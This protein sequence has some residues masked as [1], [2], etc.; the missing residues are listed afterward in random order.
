ML[1][2]V[3]KLHFS[4]SF[5]I[6]LAPSLPFVP[7]LEGSTLRR[8]IGRLRPLGKFSGSQNKSI[9]RKNRFIAARNLIWLK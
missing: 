5:R 9:R 1:V 6:D 3:L 2:I 8:H 4:F 7:D